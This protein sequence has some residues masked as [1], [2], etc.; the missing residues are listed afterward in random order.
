MFDGEHPLGGLLAVVGLH[1]GTA[2]CKLPPLRITR[3]GDSL[4]SL[5]QLE[6]RQATA[7]VYQ[8]VG[9]TRIFYPTL[10]DW[11]R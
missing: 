2:V 1:E 10:N 3:R 11:F 9:V 5:R 7:L 6:Y 8:T 4:V